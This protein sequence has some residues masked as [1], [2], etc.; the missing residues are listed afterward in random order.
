V[1]AAAIHDPRA[2][3]AA[4]PPPLVVDEVQNAP[5]LL[6]YI[7]EQVD[8][9]RRRRGQYFLSGSQNLLLLEHVAETLAGRA[10]ILRLLPFSCRELTGGRQ[11]ALPWETRKL[12]KPAAPGRGH[13]FWETIVRGQYPEVALEPRRDAWLWHASYVQ[14]RKSTR[15]NSSHRYISR[16][17]SSA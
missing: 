17:P 5:D 1:R 9:D 2:F 14:D 13:G 12:T 10:A 3:L 15:L 4:H 11:T 6:S 7:K 16:M 8:A